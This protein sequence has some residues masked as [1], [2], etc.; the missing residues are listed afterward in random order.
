[1]GRSMNIFRKILKFILFLSAALS[2]FP[3]SAKAGP[4][5]KPAVSAPSAQESIHKHWLNRARAKSENMDGRAKQELDA[6]FK[7]KLE[8]G[9]H[10]LYTYSA[11][12][13]VEAFEAAESGEPSEVTYLLTRARDLAPDFAGPDFCEGSIESQGGSLAAGIGF[14]MA[15][16]KKKLQ[17][18]QGSLP[19]LFNMV[20]I[21]LGAMFWTVVL[22]T[23]FLIA[24]YAN[25]VAHDL[26]E[27]I[28][29][30]EGRGAQALALSLLIF[31]IA[32][33][34][35]LALYGFI[36]MLFLWL[37]MS[38]RERA[39]AAIFAL[40]MLFTP[41]AFK[42]LGHSLAAPTEPP[43]RSMMR[44]REGI[45]SEQDIR[46]LEQERQT[47]D[48]QD[49]I[50][51]MTFSEAS[52]LLYSDAFE[53]AAPLFKNLIAAGDLK[54][55]STLMLGNLYFNWKKYDLALK[56][57]E[58]A[59]ELNP[60]SMA[61]YFNQYAVMSRPELVDYVGRMDDKLTRAKEIDPKGVA[62]L[63]RYQVLNPGQIVMGVRLPLD[64]MYS[65][66]MSE[67]PSKT[68]AASAMFTDLSG[69]VPLTAVIPMSIIFLVIMGILT[70]AGTKIRVAKLCE[71]CGRT[72]CYR[73]QEDGEEKVCVRCFSAFEQT[74][75]MDPRAREKVR[76]EARL[77]AEHR[78]RLAQLMSIV[79]PGSGHLLLGKTAR[80]TIFTLITSTFL[81]GLL[82]KDGILRT[83]WANPTSTIFMVIA[84]IVLIYL[85]Y[86]A[87]V[88]WNAS[89]SS[90]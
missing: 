89:A 72:Y 23:A 29:G 47:S 12:L 50:T 58:A 60:E 56:Q 13:V 62:E 20:S 32:F 90:R 66:F 79:V 52:A 33:V 30:F 45:W 80:G 22:F 78:G 19:V 21:M 11:A 48:R 68:T 86:V 69:G 59:A 57:Y 1:M 3:G 15:G 35:N 65:N 88:A 70:A 9:I 37:Y 83:P 51:D 42:V 25:A 34:P 74:A 31:P 46:I 28:H 82:Y 10:N 77:Y 81:L 76:A 84:L 67:S 24:R 38:S 41:L 27:R 43:F 87:L 53:Q 71:R 6:I 54:F 61:A 26:G 40:M 17:S 75:G 64:R 55:E 5:N 7:L 85:V 8:K 2:I 63:T 18:F 44:I 36:V 14:Y 4:R 49:T 73:C 16:S 39:I